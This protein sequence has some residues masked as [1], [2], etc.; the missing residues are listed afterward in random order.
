MER[1]YTR[2]SEINFSGAAEI[3]SCLT[4][5]FSIHYILCATNF[6]KHYKQNTCVCLCRCFLLSLSSLMKMLLINVAAYYLLFALQLLSHSYCLYSFLDVIS[7]LHLSKL[8]EA[9]NLPTDVNCTSGT[10]FLT[11]QKIIW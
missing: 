9:L 10:C 7:M 2:W 6:S 11:S 5:V 4:V 1:C 8:Q 3:R